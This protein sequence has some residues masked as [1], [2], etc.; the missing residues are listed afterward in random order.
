ML[1]E[2]VGE[3]EAWPDLGDRHTA[4]DEHFDLSCVLQAKKV[5]TVF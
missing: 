2:E 1:E 3:L 4:K 5:Q